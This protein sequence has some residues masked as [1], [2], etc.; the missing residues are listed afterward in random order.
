MFKEIILFICVLLVTGTIVNGQNCNKVTKLGCVGLN[1]ECNEENVCVYGL[2]CL[3]NPMYPNNKPPMSVEASAVDNSQN[4]SPVPATI[5]QLLGNIGDP[6]A[7]SDYCKMPLVCTSASSGNTKTCQQVEYQQLGGDCGSDTDCMETLECSPFEKVCIPSLSDSNVRNG[8]Q[9]LYDIQC[10]YNMYCNT[11]MTQFRCIDRA[12][13]GQQCGSIMGEALAVKCQEHLLCT[14]TEMI[15]GN[16]TCVEPFSLAE[17]S[18]CSTNNQNLQGV[19]GMFLSPC[20][21]SVCNGTQ[22]VV[23]QWTMPSMNCSDNETNPMGCGQFESCT[24]TNDTYS[25]VCDAEFTPTSDVFS[26]CTQMSSDFI[27]CAVDNKCQSM[28]QASLL[29]SSCIMENCGSHVCDIQ[30]K[31]IYASP[32]QAPMCSEAGFSLDKYGVCQNHA[33]AADSI[34]VVSSLSFNEN[35]NIN[36]IESRTRISWAKEAV[37]KK[38]Q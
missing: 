20:K 21:A 38:D 34:R 18:V 27:Q 26:Q 22:C 32:N 17:G 36:K 10:P 4:F 6:C 5:C 9:C 24:C 1:E 28:Y 8:H 11:T 19:N 29:P 12:T 15:D 33:S 35:F 16:S 2:G 37:T 31:C 14:V 7:N 3:Q 25:G 13:V 30:A 23:P